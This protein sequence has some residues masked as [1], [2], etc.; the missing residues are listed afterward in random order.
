MKKND[1]VEEILKP[2]ADSFAMIAK[3][4]SMDR[5]F[6]KSEKNIA[7]VIMQDP[8]KVIYA[9]IAE[10]SSACKVSEPTIIRFCR[11]IGLNGYQDLKL[12]LAKEMVSPLQAI[13]ENI[14]SDDDA[15]SVVNKVFNGTVETLSFTKNYL[16]IPDLEKAVKFLSSARRIIITG[17]GNSHAICLDLQHKLL[18]LGRDVTAY[19]D[20][21]LATIALVHADKRDVL[22]CISH[23]GSSKEVVDLA[24]QAKENQ[25]NIISITDSGITP[26]SQI[27][28]I[29][30][31]TCSNE[32]KYRIL[33]RESRIAELAI[34]DSIYTL[35]AL[36]YEEEDFLTV[37]NSLK[38][39]KY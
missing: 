27:S 35:L 15:Q 1:Y 10:L 18:R 13:N 7:K 24:Q 36:R 3:I 5:N 22:F 33:G 34:I 4:N 26:L 6:T 17:M 38:S 9:S 21:H 37:E 32:T 39:H 30:L 14:T 11:K 28:T 20:P 12:T 16:S 19:S 29:T 25:V 8:E 2:A 31:H 23:S